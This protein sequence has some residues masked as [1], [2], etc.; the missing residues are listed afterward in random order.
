MCH[1]A[2]MEARVNLGC[3]SLPLTS[4][5]SGS[6]SLLFAAMHGRLAG[7][8]ISRDVHVPAS[9]LTVGLQTRSCAQ[10]YV[11]SGSLK[12]GLEAEILTRRLLPLSVY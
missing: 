7:L 12:S 3:W 8:Q 5:E 6:L 10:P 2:N 4:F 11:D 1:S 9:H